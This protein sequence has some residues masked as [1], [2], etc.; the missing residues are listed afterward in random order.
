ME[1]T[2]K[3]KSKGHVRSYQFG[4]A[5]TLDGHLLTGLIGYQ[6]LTLPRLKNER[7]VRVQWRPRFNPA[8]DSIINAVSIGATSPFNAVSLA[9]SSSIAPGS[10]IL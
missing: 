7:G 8:R 2:E 5:W 9:H 1:I 6:F 4:L 10:T 3:S